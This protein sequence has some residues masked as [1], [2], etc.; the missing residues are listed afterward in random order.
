MIS[1]CLMKFTYY[2]HHCQCYFLPEGIIPQ[3][4]LTK[5]SHCTACG[6]VRMPVYIFRITLF[7]NLYNGCHLPL[8]F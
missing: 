1:L 5:H 8:H 3:L 7:W 2:D 6:L 4:W